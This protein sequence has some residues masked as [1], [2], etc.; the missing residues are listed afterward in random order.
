MSAEN[1]NDKGASSGCDCDLCGRDAFHTGELVCDEQTGKLAFLCADCRAG[2]EAM[3][4]K[5]NSE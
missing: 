4:R 2:H 5:V 1:E 3:V